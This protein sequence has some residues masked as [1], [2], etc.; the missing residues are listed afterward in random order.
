[1]SIWQRVGRLVSVSVLLVG[2]VG[3][4][5]CS[6]APKPKE[7]TEL[8]RILGEEGANQVKEAPGAAKYYRKSRE[9]RRASLD[10]WDEAD[11]TKAR[12]YA[13]RG[14]IAYRTA[15]AVAKQAKAKQRFE[16]ADAK[17]GKVNPQIQTLAEQRNKLRSEVQQLHQKVRKAE[18]RKAMKDRERIAAN[19]N[20]SSNDGNRELARNKLDQAL[21]AKEDA[22]DVRANEFAKGTYNRANNQLKSAQTLMNSSPDSM[23]E[24]VSSAEQAKKYFGKAAKEARPKYDEAQA[25]KNPM[26]RL[27]SLRDKLQGKFAPTNV[28]DTSRGVVVVFPGLFPK[29]SSNIIGSK[30]GD[31][32]EMAE[33]AGE[34]DEFK[35]KI[36]GYTQKGNATENLAISQVRAKRVRDYFK[37]QGISDDRMSTN[38]H[39]QG[40]IRYPDSPSRN[41]RVEVTFRLP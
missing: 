12:H 4:T 35:L 31:L 15:E 7:L 37:D 22:L 8:E 24:V 38:G 17:V 18:Q 33:L 3:L 21:E 26:E 10:E 1:M 27:A 25:K 36:D 13:V 2:F 30:R 5:A 32:R 19:A 20:S 41:D 29:E 9:L 39:G 40:R 11:L 23:S 28:E 16:A 14:K 34:F 6:Q